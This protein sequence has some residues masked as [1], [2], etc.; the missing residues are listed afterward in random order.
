MLWVN[1]SSFLWPT[2]LVC[3]VPNCCSFFESPCQNLF[4]YDALG[5]KL[6]MDSMI[7]P[8]VI[9]WF[10][11]WE[12]YLG[13]RCTSAAKQPLNVGRVY[14]SAFCAINPHSKG[15]NTQNQSWSLSCQVRHLKICTHMHIHMQKH[16]YMHIEN[17]RHM[18]ITDACLYPS[19]FQVNLL[20]KN[21]S[22]C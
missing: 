16:A 19:I 6:R 11:W 13:K 2:T 4:L 14:H 3:S 7:K 17:S 18:N 22:T 9:A 20:S 15:I 8:V 10:G 21:R 12:A 1:I 5:S